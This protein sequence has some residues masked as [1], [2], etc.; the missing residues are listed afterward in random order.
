RKHKTA[1][2]PSPSAADS[3]NDEP[4]A[5]PAKK[6]KSKA[7]TAES[8][9]PKQARSRKAPSAASSAGLKPS[10]PSA[11]GGPSTSSLP[12]AKPDVGPV[13][14]KPRC[15]AGPS[16]PKA[17]TSKLSSS[18][19]AEQPVP[20][21]IVAGPSKQKQRTPK[22]SS[23]A[24]AEQP[25]PD[26]TAATPT[27][28]LQPRKPSGGASSSVGI[29]RSSS[30][31][32]PPS[33]APRPA[34][35]GLPPPMSSPS[36]GPA[37][38]P[39][40]R[41][42]QPD[43]IPAVVQRQPRPQPRK[44]PGVS[45]RPPSP[46]FFDLS[47]PRV[48]RGL[49]Q[50]AMPAVLDHPGSER[51][52]DAAPSAAPGSPAAYALPLLASKPPASGSPPHKAPTPLASD[53][54]ERPVVPAVSVTK[55]ARHDL[56]SNQDMTPAGPRLL[57]ASKPPPGHRKAPAYLASDGANLPVVPAAGVTRSARHDLVSNQDTTPAGPRLLLAPKPPP[58]RSPLHKAHAPLASDGADRRVVPAASVTKGA[59]D[60]DDQ[61]YK[62]VNKL[63]FGYEV[64]QRSRASLSGALRPTAHSA[65]SASAG[66]SSEGKSSAQGGSVPQPGL[67]LSTQGSTAV[68]PP[69]SPIKGTDSPL[70]WQEKMSALVAQQRGTTAPVRVSAKRK[71][72][73]GSIAVQPAA[74]PATALGASLRSAAPT[75]SSSRRP[76]VG[77][78]RSQAAEPTATTASTTR[79]VAS[80]SAG[81][82]NTYQPQSLSQDHGQH[83]RTGFQKRSA[84]PPAAQAQNTKR[85]ARASMLDSRDARI[86]KSTS[87]PRSPSR[88]RKASLFPN[89]A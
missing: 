84:K 50:D 36:S 15:D 44:P 55:S 42:P 78:S 30:A 79:S 39:P 20:E 1:A 87:G 35:S 80:S 38:L 32:V 21:P 46:D 16:K 26:R 73:G 67:R 6:A 61:G 57:L 86:D 75:P 11:A 17:R 49:T 62:V 23:S 66:P 52:E 48:G 34:S 63:G 33:P 29:S 51:N 45:P 41:P 71:H 60:L 18:A 76:D 28:A 64:P 22:A 83:K 47:R 88:V 19:S 72:D 77:G 85:S 25:V 14:K 89:D 56:G 7:K 4:V 13:A 10:A 68:P 53:G 40:P 65:P 8:A 24:S 58:A 43:L 9:E 3:D 27:P 81:G 69:S 70:V 2:A 37:H 54:A 74:Q 5:P 12:A 31:V 59:Q 82:S